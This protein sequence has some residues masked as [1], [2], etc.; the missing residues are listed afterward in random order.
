M[1][2]SPWYVHGEGEK[3]RRGEEEK[4]RGGEEEGEKGRRGEESCVALYDVVCLW[5]IRGVRC[6]VCGTAVCEVL[7]LIQ[8]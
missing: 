3:R 6:M 4:R 5:A 1:C 2:Y 7:V 8:V